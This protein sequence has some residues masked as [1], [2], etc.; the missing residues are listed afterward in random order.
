MGYKNESEKL[1]SL[2][3]EW[4]ERWLEPALT[5]RPQRRKKFVND[6]GLNIKPV[7]TSIDLEEAGF[8]YERDLGFPGRFPFTRGISPLMYRSE[9]WIIRAYSGFGEPRACNMRYKKLAES[10]ADEIVMAVDLPTQV[11]YDSDHVM[12]RGEVGKVGVAI[13]TLRDME[14]LFEDI[15]LNSLKRVSMLGNSFGPIA[16]ALFIAL[17]EKQGLKPQDFVIDLQNDV[18]KEYVA[19]G[20]YIFPVQPAV[21]V[22]TDVVSYCAQHARHW[23]PLTFC[24]NH[25]NAAG[26]GSSRA[27]AFA[28]ANGV[29]YIRELLGK[30]HDID[31]IAP[32]FTMFLDERMDFFVAI[33]HLRAARRVW[34]KV[35]K[36]T[37]G[38]QN[39]ESMA[40]KITAYSHGG[41]TLLEPVN[42]IVRITLAALA[43]A[44]GG[45]Q[46]LYNASYDEVL[47]T[48]TE[49]A[50]KIAVRTQQILAYELGITS[51]VDPLGG[52][53]YIENLT[54]QI[55]NQIYEEFLKVEERGGAIPAIETGYI[56]THLGD[57]AIRRQKEFEQGERVSIGV[58]KYRTGAKAPSG[59]FRIDPSIEAKQLDR[60]NKVKQE[61]D[62]Q[63]VRD[64]LSYVKKAAEEEGNL[65]PPVL[66]AVRAYASIGEICDV[67]RGVFGEYQ[68][69]EYYAASK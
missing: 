29:C 20:T 63:R 39:Q 56:A 62:S 17:G 8:N 3:R 43:Y 67:L 24:A 1:K 35:L 19:R 40:L 55:E 53:Y 34:A 14:I 25:L 47:G 44:L 36:E 7:Y 41:E 45:V 23:Y 61:R 46:F 5:K 21:R 42:N 59:A 4:E 38:A 69:R 16:L 10:G 12:A 37:L 60:L 2:E 28:L 9:P 13:D 68:R 27:T 58:N 51:T 15:P 48:P 6:I 49:E 18:L 65:V 52:S 30:G 57:G 11:G 66:E 26:A 32:L 50:S 22:A 31:E 54:T 64:T 33:S